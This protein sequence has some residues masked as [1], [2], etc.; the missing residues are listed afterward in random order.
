MLSAELRGEPYSK[1][2]HR[3]RLLPV[4]DGR[5][6]SAIERKHGNISAVLL[7]LDCPYIQGYKPYSN[8]QRLLFDVVQAWL[9]RADYLEAPIR[10]CNDAAIVVP[11]FDD[12]L[13]AMVD[14]P[15]PQG[16]AGRVSDPGPLPYGPARKTNYLDLERRNSA[17]GLA[18]EEFVLDFERARLARLGCDQLAAS[19]EHVAKTQGDGQGFDILSFEESGREKLVEV[20]TT[21]YGAQ[22]PFFVTRNEVQVSEDRS[23]QYDLYRVYSFRSVPK[24]FSLRGSI[25]QSFELQPTQYRARLA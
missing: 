15:E 16:M 2:E 18:G 20:K 14:P 8:Y 19:V 21:K 5:S 4:L 13:S 6:E 12:I 9:A 22:T 24:L 17:L 7:E 11:A 1:A 23:D 3:R 10:A 25:A